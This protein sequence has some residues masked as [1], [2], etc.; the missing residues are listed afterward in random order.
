MFANSLKGRFWSPEFNSAASKEIEELGKGHPTYAEE[1]PEKVK[2]LKEEL[3]GLLK[4]IAN[5]GDASAYEWQHL[6]HFIIISVKDALLAMHKRYPDFEEKPGESFNEVMNELIELFYLFESEG[7]FTLQRICEVVLEPEKN[8]KSS[9]KF[10]YAI[11]RVG[12][13]HSAIQHLSIPVETL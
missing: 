11:E 7:P 12:I 10:I 4:E 9:N 13:I 6:K 8:Y 2:H 3:K 5:T 1:A